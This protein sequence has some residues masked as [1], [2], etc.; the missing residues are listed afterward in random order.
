M[1][2]IEGL[3]LSGG[4]NVIL[5]VVDRLS[6]YEHF[7]SLKH[8][9][10]AVD[11]ALK[12]VQ[13]IVRLHGFPRSI[14]SDRDRVFLSAFWKE[15]FKLAGTQLNYITSFHPQ[16]DGQT[17]VLNRCPETYLRYFALG[18]P[19]LWS[20]FLCW[21]EFWFNTSYHTSLKTSPFVVVYG[22]D[23]PALLPFEEGST[24]NFELEESLKLRNE[25]LGHLKG[26]LER[27]QEL[28]K[29]HADKHRRDVSFE[30]LDLVFLE[31]RPYRQKSVATRFCPKLAAKFY[32]PYKIMEK[33]GKVAYRLQ[34]PPGSKIHDVFH[35]SQLKKAVGTDVEVLALPPV[36]STET[37][38]PLQPLDVLA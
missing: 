4:V 2:F 32:G 16:T 11:V 12:F 35:V 38:A 27:A 6:K 17:E 37:E 21:A 3:P 9:F 25:M 26:C 8:P 31:L 19:R 22:R 15:S 33:I 1:D 14:V 18:H 10:T 28:M 13:E 29:G 20:K 7:I 34:L 36:F 5:V 23:P 30:V 24:T